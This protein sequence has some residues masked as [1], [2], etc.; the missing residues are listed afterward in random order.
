MLEA[1]DFGQN[2]CILKA[3]DSYATKGTKVGD[4]ITILGTDFEVVGIVQMTRVYSGIIVPYAA[5]EQIAP[6]TSMQHRYLF[7]IKDDTEAKTNETESTPD[8]TMIE[9]K[10][11]QSGADSVDSI[12]SIREEEQQI[13]LPSIKKNQRP[14]LIAGTVVFLFA[15]FSAWNI[16]SGRMLDEK[17]SYGIKKAV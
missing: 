1:A 14:W 4:T 13:I 12:M 6:K 9:S 3:T 15:L 7:E 11:L 17:H 10:V 8:E 2:V 16:F 5:M